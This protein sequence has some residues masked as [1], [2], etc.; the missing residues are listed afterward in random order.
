MF[1][2][3][4]LV[5]LD[6]TT[7]HIDICIAEEA[8]KLGIILFCAPDETNYV[9]QPL[10]MSI[11]DSFE[12]NWNREVQQL[13]KNPE[14]PTAALNQFGKLFTIAWLSAMSGNNIQSGKIFILFF[15][16]FFLSKFVL[17]YFL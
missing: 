2:G 4:C 9:L 1:V 13:C 12:T 16:C 6:E 14:D 7:C 15:G 10:K 17:K 11:F 3:N 5:I 8:Q